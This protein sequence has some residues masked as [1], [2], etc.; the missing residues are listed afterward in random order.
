MPAVDITL[1]QTTALTS[2]S[3][4]SCLFNFD[5]TAI[6]RLSDLGLSVFELPRYRQRRKHGWDRP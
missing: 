1:W 2:T 3:F 4:V 5:W 6:G